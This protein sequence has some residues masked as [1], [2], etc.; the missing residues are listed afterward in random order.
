MGNA[1]LSE[2]PRPLFTCALT[3]KWSLAW[4]FHGSCCCV[5]THRRRA[6]NGTQSFGRRLNLCLHPRGGKG[7]SSGFWEGLTGFGIVITL[8][9]HAREVL[10]PVVVSNNFSPNFRAKYSNLYTR[11]LRQYSCFVPYLFEIEGKNLGVNRLT[12]WIKG[13]FYYLVLSVET[14]VQICEKSSFSFFGDI[15]VIMYCTM[16]CMVFVDEILDD[17][18]RIS[19][20]KGGALILWRIDRVLRG[21][22]YS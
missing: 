1:Y 3:C 20:C 22:S 2:H 21:P 9:G 18:S 7:M 13:G 11:K 19:Y 14:I 10:L 15:S 12:R 17:I 16:I 8:R 6:V 5:V 4:R